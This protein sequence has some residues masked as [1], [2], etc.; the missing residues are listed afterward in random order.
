MN[1]KPTE[2]EAAYLKRMAALQFPGSRENFST[3]HPIHFLEEQVDEYIEIPMDEYDDYKDELVRIELCTY[4]CFVF[5]TVEELVA[6]HLDIDLTDEEE[7]REYNRKAKEY[8]TP[9]FVSY[10][11]ALN[12]E[13]IPGTDES[14]YSL[15]D[16]L[17]A[18]DIDTDCVRLCRYATGWDV[19]A[20]SFTH[21]GAEEMREEL[22]NHIFRPTRYYAYT[23]VDGDF[24]VLMGFLLKYGQALLNE[25]C[26]GLKW[27]EE[28]R[29]TREQAIR[30]YDEHPNSPFCLASYRFTL[31]AQMSE[32]GKE[33]AAS[34]RITASGEIHRY[35]WHETEV[36]LAQLKVE[37]DVEGNR[38]EF[39]YPF[40]CDRMGEPLE[41]PRNVIALLNFARYC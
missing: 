31:P 30:C 14:I 27:N 1:I 35:P 39:D 7:V 36:P 32:D 6:D 29:L 38:K 16:Y 8:G 5:D 22:D 2:K 18:Y 23:T 28:M 33:H 20:V 15:Y 3:R 9:Q 17:R 21:K 4:D 26:E 19:K 25:E 11:E 40:E 10:E 37:Y 34:I 13:C 12:A 41:D 24:P